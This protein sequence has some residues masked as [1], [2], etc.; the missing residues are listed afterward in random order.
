LRLLAV[1]A[2]IER[3]GYPLL[4]DALAALVDIRWR[5]EI[6]GSLDRDPATVAD[7]RARLAATAL[8]ERVRLRGE[9]PEDELAAAY[10]GAD[11]FVSA[12]LYE[13]YGMALAEAMAWG[14]PI[15]TT[16]EGAAGETVPDGAALKVR[17]GDRIA[18]ANA[19]RRVLT[20][21]ALRGRLADK[22]Y[23]AGQALPSWA[24]AARRLA[25]VLRRAAYSRD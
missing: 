5:L 10:D 7:V 2:V 18:L 13:G 25:A 19:L 11:L 1:G 21:A 22:S 14:L 15:V 4:I 12:S 3:K 6:V 24:D 16:A 8:A 9:V 20:D 23:A 17:G